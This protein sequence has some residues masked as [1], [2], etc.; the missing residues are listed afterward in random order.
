[1]IEAYSNVNARMVDM[2]HTLI[3]SI[4]MAKS[5]LLLPTLETDLNDVHK[6][7][8][9]VWILQQRMFCLSYNSYHFYLH[10]LLMVHGHKSLLGYWSIYLL[11]MPIPKQVSLTMGLHESTLA[12]KGMFE[13][14]NK[15]GDKLLTLLM[16]W[17][18]KLHIQ[19][20]TKCT[21]QWTNYDSI[22]ISCGS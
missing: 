9:I 18:S 2:V 12:R 21:G 7:A 15:K 17:I 20:T 16:N 10:K 19:P 6:I 22:H 13:F 8:K 14:V 1:M 4:I 11:S 3:G 5:S